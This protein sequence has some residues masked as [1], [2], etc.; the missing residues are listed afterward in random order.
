MNPCWESHLDCTETAGQLF[1]SWKHRTY[2]STRMPHPYLFQQLPT[3][4]PHS[5]FMTLKESTKQVEIKWKASSEATRYF[6]SCPHPFTST[7][8]F[9]GT[10]VF[11]YSN[12]LLSVAVHHSGFLR[13]RFGCVL[14]KMKSLAS[15]CTLH[16]SLSISRNPLHSM[17]KSFPSFEGEIMILWILRVNG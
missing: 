6:W 3:V 7:I 1:S 10:L 8:L 11:T 9:Q 2:T 5:K 15:L 17:P 14:S 13:I 16:I 12:S 4:N